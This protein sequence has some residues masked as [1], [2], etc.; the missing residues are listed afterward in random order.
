MMCQMTESTRNGQAFW[1]AAFWKGRFRWSEWK[2]WLGGAF[3][4]L[5]AAVG[6]Y[7][8]YHEIPR[9]PVSLGIYVLIFFYVTRL[10]LKARREARDK[11]KDK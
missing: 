8:I 2:F 3:L 6:V 7:Q 5:M 4:V 10:H 11:N 9:E 1:H